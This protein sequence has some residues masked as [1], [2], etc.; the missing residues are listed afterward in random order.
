MKAWAIFVLVVIASC[1][2]ILLN[3]WFTKSKA[4]S[5]ISVILFKLP[6]SGSSW[7][8]ERLNSYPNVFLCKEIM[9]RRDNITVTPEQQM[10]G[11]QS[12]LISPSDKLRFRF[13]TLP[14]PSN[15]FLNDF[16]VSSKWWRTLD[17]VGF[18]LNPEHVTGRL[19]RLLVLC[20]VSLPSSYCIGG[21]FVGIDWGTLLGNSANTRLVVLRRSNVIKSAISGYCPRWHLIRVSCCVD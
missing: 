2:H 6:R 14:L 7:M 3:L 15:R 19:I 1:L 17:I 9:Q 4:M 21:V 20:L 11:L 12:A 8:T 10:A 13:R 5:P 16:I 18:T